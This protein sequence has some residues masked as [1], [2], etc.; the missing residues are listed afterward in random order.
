MGYLLACGC[1]IWFAHP[2]F[3]T[4][5][6]LKRFAAMTFSINITLDDPRPGAFSM[7]AK[8]SFAS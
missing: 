2:G 6:T 7:I 8:Q 3:A 5:G 4:A 1:V